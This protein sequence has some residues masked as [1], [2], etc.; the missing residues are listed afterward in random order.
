MHDFL[1]ARPRAREDG[2]KS[3]RLVPWQ[4]LPRLASFSCLS[5][6]PL[7]NVIRQLRDTLILINKIFYWGYRAAN[8]LWYW[9]RRRFT[10]AGLCVAG[11]II[12]TGAAELDT[13]N[14]VTYQ[15]F[16][17][18]L[19]LLLLAFTG[20]LSFRSKY[21]ATRFL[22]RIG[23]VGQAL[24]YRVAI[25]NL[26]AKNQVGLMLLEDP[27]NPPPAFS[28][29]LAFHRAES[30]RVRPFRPGQ[31][32]RKSP[33]QLM[34]AKPVQVPPL[35]A[36][37]ET[38]IPV[39]ILPLRRGTLRF[40]SVTLGRPD[41]F[42]LFRS[43]IKVPAAQTVLI[44]PKRYP[45]PPIALP[46]ALRFQ[47]GG[48][49]PAANIGRDGEFVALREYRRGDPLRHVH[50]RTWAK[51][52]RPVVKE[53][54]DESFMRHALVLDT[55]DSEPSSEIFEEAVSVAA[56]FACTVLTQESQLDLLFVNHHSFGFAAGRGHGHAEEML[57]ILASVRHCAEPFET[58]E[59]LV[60]NHIVA[61]DGCI[62]VLLKW[63]EARKRLV[64]KL[65]M[66]GVPLLVLVVMQ[67]GQTE[68]DAGPLQDKPE[69][70]HVLEIG[71][72]A[73]K[74]AKLR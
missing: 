10:P 65:R 9:S 11:G 54:E 56:S 4:V 71:N 70:L 15:S 26:T 60:L 42:G 36:Y 13:V 61:V 63:D 68:L 16:A 32:R 12:I 57:K 51:T 24:H 8:G 27:V 44:L 34:V 38:E 46:G 59:C 23:T 69:C 64:E 41:P 47:E 73:E 5:V 66:Q 40:N 29:W 62:C 25:K 45:V 43:L 58:L 53:F 39:E 48:V 52:G 6:R 18:L 7:P 19:G 20:G 49:A 55:F 28:E 50:W 1:A 74:L 31:R 35:P 22:P 2:R 17:S 72:I 14:T 21:S 67:P 30:R 3:A 33:F 37:H